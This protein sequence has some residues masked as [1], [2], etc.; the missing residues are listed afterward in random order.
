MCHPR[1]GSTTLSKTSPSE[2]FLLLLLP[3]TWMSVICFRIGRPS[4][5][6]DDLFHI[7]SVPHTSL[8]LARGASG[9][10]D[11]QRKTG[12]GSFVSTGLSPEWGRGG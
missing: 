5:L 12:N 7:S 1:R 6:A 10:R 2:A 9:T 3:Y 11:K 4:R 8:G